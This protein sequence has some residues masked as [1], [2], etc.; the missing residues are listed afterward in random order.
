MRWREGVRPCEVGHVAVYL[1][2]MVMVPGPS[3]KASQQQGVISIKILHE[4][5]LAAVAS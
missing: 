3:C 2:L 5:N 1:A 4:V